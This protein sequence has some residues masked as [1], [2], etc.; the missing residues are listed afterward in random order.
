MYNGKHLINGQLV[1]GKGE[2]V[3]V[4]NP[5]TE[6]VTSE[7]HGIDAEQTEKPWTL[8]RKPFRLGPNFR[9]KSAKSI[10]SGLR[11]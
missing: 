8:P 5:A 1:E 10:S 6:E 2:K 4:L 9:S 7:F 3:S 11:I